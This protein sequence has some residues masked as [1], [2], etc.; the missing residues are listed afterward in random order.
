M[1]VG[2][3]HIDQ[4]TFLTFLMAGDPADG[5]FSATVHVVDESDQRVVAST[6]EMPVMATPGAITLVAP[7]LLMT[8]GRPGLYSVRLNFGEEEN[9]RGEFHIAQGIPSLGR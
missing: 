4:P 3:Q 7:T 6:A 5:T 1:T 2:I 9:F 8:F